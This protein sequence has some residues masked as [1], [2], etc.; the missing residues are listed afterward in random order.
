MP[1]GQYVYL[2]V[3]DVRSGRVITFQDHRAELDAESDN[4]QVCF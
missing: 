3:K 2:I 1:A 4:V